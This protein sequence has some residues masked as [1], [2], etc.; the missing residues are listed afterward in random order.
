MS[1]NYGKFFMDFLTPFFEGLLS[2]FKEFFKGLFKMFNVLD[3]IDTVN[4]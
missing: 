3:Y 1:N 4:K 2:I